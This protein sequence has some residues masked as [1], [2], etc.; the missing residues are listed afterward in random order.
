MTLPKPSCPACG[1]PPEDITWLGGSPPL[2]P[3]FWECCKCGHRWET[4]PVAIVSRLSEQE[5]DAFRA[6]ENLAE[7]TCPELQGPE[8]HLD[9]NDQYPGYQRA[10]GEPAARYLQ[11][12]SS[13]A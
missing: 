4:P 5:Y 10:G 12:Y 3:D 13:D 11:E 8:W 6:A 1:A 7:L 2:G 9:R